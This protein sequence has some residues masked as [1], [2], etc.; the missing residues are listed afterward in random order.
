MSIRVD[1]KGKIFTEIVRKDKVPVLMQT[2]TNVVHG[3]IFLRPEQRI[4]DALNESQEMFIAVADAEVYAPNGQ[5]LHRD[6]FLTVNKQHIV[7]IRPEPDSP[8]TSQ[9]KPA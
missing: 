2:L 9:N 7:W 6:E 5:L 8:Q 1:A 3:Y 4:R